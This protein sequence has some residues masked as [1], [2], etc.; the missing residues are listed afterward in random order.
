VF[1]ADHFRPEHEGAVRN[2]LLAQIVKL[3]F[4]K[5]RILVVQMHRCA[6]LQHRVTECLKALVVETCGCGG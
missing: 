6:E 5:M 4:V 1:E 3:P 2:E